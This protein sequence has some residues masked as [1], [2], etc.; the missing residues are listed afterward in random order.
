M[1][2]PAVCF[3]GGRKPAEANLVA[4]FAYELTELRKASVINELNS[5]EDIEALP[6]DAQTRLLG[7]PSGKPN[8]SDTFVLVPKNQRFPIDGAVL[9]LVSAKPVNTTQWYRSQVAAEATSPEERKAALEEYDRL[10]PEDQLYRWYVAI[11]ETGDVVR[12]KIEESRFLSISQEH[13]FT[14]PPASPYRTKLSQALDQYLL[15]KRENPAST[16]KPEVALGPKGIATPTPKPPSAPVTP[17]PAKSSNP[18][19]WIIGAIAALVA[20]VL[21]VRRNKKPKA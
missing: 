20:V 21:V 8:I 7:P 13:K 16:S 12:E 1:A 6:Q 18:L 10:N 5:W 14:V 19:W 9:L 3:G 17:S 11:A 4:K 2:L 15:S